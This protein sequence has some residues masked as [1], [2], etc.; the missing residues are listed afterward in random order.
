[1]VTQT[2]QQY[3][4]NQLNRAPVLLRR[5]TEDKQGKQFIKRQAYHE[6]RELVGSFLDGNTQVR[7]VAIPGLRG[8]G[9][10]TIL[11]Q[12]Y[13]ELYP[14]FQE[15][16]LFIS[17]DQIINLLNA[18]LYTVLEEYQHI[19]GVSFEKLDS[20]IVLFID[21]V[22][23]DPKWQA[24]LKA[25]FD[26]SKQVFVFCTGSSALSLQ[27][28]PDL[29]RRIL[30]KTLYPLDFSE[31]IQLKSSYTEDALSPVSSAHN[32]SKFN[33]D[34]QQQLRTALFDSDTVV[35][36]HSSLQNLQQATQKR[37]LSIEEFD[38]AQ[39]L[40]YGSMPF[41]LGVQ[42]EL[43]YSLMNELIDR[44][45]QK[46]LATV[47]SLSQETLQKIKHILLM[48]A[49]SDTVSLTSMAKNLTDI[50][51]NTLI[52]V[53]EALEQAE[54]LLRIYPYGSATKK[55]RKPSKFTFMSPA[56]RYTLL[57][58]V[59]GARAF[60][61]YKGK[62]L[63]DIVGLTLHKIFKEQVYYDSAKGGADF[64]VQSGKKKIVIEVGFGKKGINQVEETMKKIDARYGLLISEQPMQLFQEK[65]ILS[66]PLKQF[67]FLK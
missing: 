44:V 12:L 67:L 3:L 26:R 7:M 46:D 22:H 23:F 54:M 37:L 8:V 6:L 30:F 9:K 14:Q 47:H 53:F 18:D 13:T 25:V 40:Q 39:Y 38:V 4:Q 36:A 19:L 60:E 63:E 11:A 66:V 27:S 48:L 50:A 32:G 51:M 52:D 59:D 43:S 35:D 16:I 34:L 24:V 64:I 21:E 45:I 28:T 56:I 62:Y 15:R 58:T 1:M 10:T 31:Y 42:S 61:Q 57:S 17:V 41:T 2:V 5:Y 65:N 33:G 29:A 55:M 20:P 49:A